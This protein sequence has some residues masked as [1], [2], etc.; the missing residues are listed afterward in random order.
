MTR[1]KKTE[2]P[3]PLAQ[4]ELCPSY[5]PF[6]QEQAFYCRLFNTQLLASP[7][8]IFKCWECM[9][10]DVRKSTYKAKIKD[11]EKRV[12]LWD[13]AVKRKPFD[14]RGKIK[15]TLAD[16]KERKVFKEFL[17]SLAGKI[18]ALADKNLSKLLLNLYL[19]LDS[20]EKIQML[21]LLSNPQTATLLIN[22]IKMI[23][24]TADVLKQV[25]KEMDAIA[26]RQQKEQEEILKRRY[27]HSQYLGN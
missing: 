10:S 23:G 6:L 20:F 26:L 25:R 21:D 14:L 16:W 9:N 2:E 5:C 15:T 8:H 4:K 7:P 17:M 3:L 18:P 12:Y 24:K 22:K 27:E 1:K 13:K 19:V 11:F